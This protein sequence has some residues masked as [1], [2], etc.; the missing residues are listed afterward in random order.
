MGQTT[1]QFGRRRLTAS[2]QQSGSSEGD[3]G[4]ISATNRKWEHYDFATDCATSD[5]PRLIHPSETWD[6][7]RD[8]YIKSLGGDDGSDDGGSGFQNHGFSI[9]FNVRDDGP[10]GRSIYAAELIPKG[11]KFYKSSESCVRFKEKG[12]LKNYLRLLPHDLQCDILLWAWATSSGA[13][14]CLDEGSYMNHGEEPEM[15]THHN[16][17]TLRDIQPGEELLENYSSYVYTDGGWFNELRGR[18]W[19]EMKD[20]EE[21]GAEIDKYTNQGAVAVPEQH[22]RAVSGDGKSLTDGETR[23]VRGHNDESEINDQV[24]HLVTP[25]SGEKSKYV[26]RFTHVPLI[27]VAFLVSSFLLTRKRCRLSFLGSKEKRGI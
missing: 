10:R 16:T 5:Y 12:G 7:L 1:Q 14:V 13:M 24:V 27:L 3:G 9:P 15:R 8:A 11:T 18:S 17:K 6:F 26:E 2:D 25:S 21:G 22:Q 23:T 19:G 20:T 4:G